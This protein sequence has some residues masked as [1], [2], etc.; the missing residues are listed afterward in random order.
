MRISIRVLALP[1]LI[2]AGLSAC[3]KDKAEQPH[4]RKVTYAE[5]VEPIMKNHCTECHTSGKRGAVESGLLTDSYRSRAPGSG[6][7]SNPV[8]P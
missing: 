1:L 3:H 8:L 2:S 7:L 5:D 4:I 6:R